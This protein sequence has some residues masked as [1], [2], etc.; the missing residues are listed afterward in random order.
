MEY[1]IEEKEGF[2]VVGETKDM[3]IESSKVG[4]NDF[5]VEVNN[6]GAI[7]KIHDI[8]SGSSPITH[9]RIIAVWQVSEEDDTHI[10][11][12]IGAEYIQGSNI[13]PLKIVNIPKTKWMIFS[14]SG[15]L[16]EALNNSYKTIFEDVLPNT[17][18]QISTNMI[19]EVYTIDD[20][21]QDNY[22]FEIW[23]PII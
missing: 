4:I 6:N 19:V 20:S 21:K 16:P 23:V 8:K 18:Y 15:I 2:R 9:G 5:W 12:T 7:D 13:Y 11:Y 10:K 1:V 3:T 17:D 14:C 22:R